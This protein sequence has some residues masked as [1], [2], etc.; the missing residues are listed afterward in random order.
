MFSIQSRVPELKYQEYLPPSP[1]EIF[2]PCFESKIKEKMLQL[3]GVGDIKKIH[4][5]EG[6]VNRK[7]LEQ[8][9][10]IKI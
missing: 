3:R 5:I 2:S 1:S 10:P 8:R 7:F 9:S 6:V 4:C